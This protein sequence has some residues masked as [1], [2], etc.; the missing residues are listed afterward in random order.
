LKAL[1]RLILSYFQNLIHLVSQLSDADMLVLA[2]NE[3]AK[4]IPYV[5]SSR[6]AV[7]DYLKARN[8]YRSMRYVLTS[9]CRCVSTYG[10]RLRT[11]S[12]LRHF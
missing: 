2:L 10:L 12:V 1:Q 6:K 7:K 4:A 11:M 9:A 8:D 3:S 5:I